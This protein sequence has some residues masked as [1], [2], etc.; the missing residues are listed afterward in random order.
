MMRF[1]AAAD[2]YAIATM[3]GERRRGCVPSQVNLADVK[4]TGPGG[5]VLKEDILSFV[6]RRDAPAKTPAAAPTPEIAVPPPP[7]PPP[8]PPSFA[9]LPPR[10]PVDRADSVVQLKGE[11]L[12]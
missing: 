7:P 11:S 3:G 2:R 10:P 12:R 1:T 6:T 5:R 9:A 8:A 4:G